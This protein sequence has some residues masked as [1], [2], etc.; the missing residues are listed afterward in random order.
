ME[1]KVKYHFSIHINFKKDVDVIALSKKFNLTPYKLTML[2]ESKGNVKTAKMFYKT[3]DIDYI[4]T[5][6]KFE[7]FMLEMKE[8]FKELPLYLKE[9]NGVCEFAIVFTDLKTKPC[10]HFSEKTIEAL[11]LLNASVDFDFLI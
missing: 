1:N 4:Y 2:N 6:E 7:K 3:N 5:G 10:L 9:Y 11:N 8:I